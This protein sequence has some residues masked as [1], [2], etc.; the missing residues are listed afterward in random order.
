M[1]AMEGRSVGLS[2]TTPELNENGKIPKHLQGIKI[3]EV[4]RRSMECFFTHRYSQNGLLY[5]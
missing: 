1:L 4:M 2:I 5:H 3:L